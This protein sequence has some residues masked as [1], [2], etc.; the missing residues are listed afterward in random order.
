MQRNQFSK[1]KILANKTLLS[2]WGRRQGTD[3][4]PWL[5]LICGSELQSSLC[6]AKWW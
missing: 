5:S 4:P 3:L 1:I 6:G 2:P